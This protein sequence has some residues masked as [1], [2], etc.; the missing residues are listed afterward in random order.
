MELP[1]LTP[2]LVLPTEDPQIEPQFELDEDAFAIALKQIEQGDHRLL[3]AAKMAIEGQILGQFEH[4][5]RTLI[6]RKDLVKEIEKAWA[7]WE[8][9]RDGGHAEITNCALEAIPLVQQLAEIYDRLRQLPVGPIYEIEGLKT[10]DPVRLCG[11]LIRKATKNLDHN[12]RAWAQPRQGW[13]A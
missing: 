4:L 9:R 8:K 11:A 7:K 6:G 13:D 2:D 5:T 3:K 12:Q 1:D 10:D